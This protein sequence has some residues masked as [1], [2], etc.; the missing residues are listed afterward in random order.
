MNKILRKIFI[1]ITVLGKTGVSTL[2]TKPIRPI[3]FDDLLPNFHMLLQQTATQGSHVRPQP[4]HVPLSLRG[5][6]ERDYDMK[7]LKGRLEGLREVK[8]EQRDL[9]G[10]HYPPGEKARNR[11]KAS[12][13]CFMMGGFEIVDYSESINQLHKKLLTKILLNK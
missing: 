8:A 11:D 2:K 6:T 9:E 4:E 7:T 1:E 5:E 12:I 3:T 13:S 10:E